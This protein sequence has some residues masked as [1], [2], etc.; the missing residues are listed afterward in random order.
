M[1]SLLR[2]VVILLVFVRLVEIRLVMILVENKIKIT[3]DF[4]VG[5]MYIYN[6]FNERK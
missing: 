3:I 2:V 6:T 4:L 1:G 5:M